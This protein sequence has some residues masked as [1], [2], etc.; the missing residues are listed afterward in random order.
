MAE[1]RLSFISAFNERVEPLMNGTVEAEG[2]ELIPTYSHPAETFWRQLKFGEFEVAEMSMSSYL[3]A[4]SQ[5]ADMIALAVFPSRRLFQTELSYHADSGIAKPED[6]T[7]KRLGVAEYQQTAALWIRGILEHDF[8]VSQ[9]KIHW[10][11]ERS[12]EMSHGAATGFKPPAGIS[13]NQIAPNKSLASTLLEKEL[14][15]AHVASPWV[16]QAN[17][18]DRSSRIAGKGDWSKIKPL[19]P[20]R[21]AEGARFVEKHGFLPVNH[22][23]IIRGDIYKKYPW[24][25]VNLYTGFVEAKALAR[26]K[27]L[28]RIPSALFFGPEYAAMTRDIIGDDPFPYGIKANQAM[29][30]TITGYS[31]EQGLTPRKMAVEELFAESTLDL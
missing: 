23:Y 19:F 14:D 11:M 10:C 20:D 17:A 18:L 21:M 30:D 3:I 26:E 4:R 15:V 2:I 27:L 16:L 12:E 1:L 6:L 5:G 28:E 22:T 31:Y 7:G 29:L 9:Y 13:F 25:G 8:D 24:V